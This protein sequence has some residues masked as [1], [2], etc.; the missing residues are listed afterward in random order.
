MSVEWLVEPAPL[1]PRG[2]HPASS[3][4]LP[5]GPGGSLGLSSVSLSWMSLGRSLQPL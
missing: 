4:P 2:L 5:S 1:G 3:F